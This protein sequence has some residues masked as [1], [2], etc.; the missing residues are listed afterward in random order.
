MLDGAPIDT[1]GA[2][3]SIVGE[4]QVERYARAQFVYRQPS[5]SSVE[6]SRHHRTP[7]E[8]VL[9]LMTTAEALVTQSLRSPAATAEYRTAPTGWL[10]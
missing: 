3:T 8:P 4:H 2:A 5:G 1:S 9:R 6:V 10:T 7:D